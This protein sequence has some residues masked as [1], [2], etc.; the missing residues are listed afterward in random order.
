[1]KLNSILKKIT[2]SDI[3]NSL[4][5]KNRIN[6]TKKKKKKEKKDYKLNI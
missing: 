2:N 6:K 3:N 4:L 5:I 1:M